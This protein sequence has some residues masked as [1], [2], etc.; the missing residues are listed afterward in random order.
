MPAFPF[1]R[2]RKMTMRR[3]SLRDV[4]DIVAIVL[5]VTVWVVVVTGALAWA[6]ER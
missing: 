1:L 3:L 2:A 6:H 4:R 5:M